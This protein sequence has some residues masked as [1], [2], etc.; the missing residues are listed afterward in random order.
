MVLTATFH[1]VVGH[2]LGSELMGHNFTKFKVY[3]NGTGNAWWEYVGEPTVGEK[4]FILSAGLALNL[5]LALVFFSLAYVFR[6]KFFFSLF[7][8]IFGFVNF[9][10]SVVY[11]FWNAIQPIGGSGD[12]G[13]ILAFFPQYRLFFIIVAGI[14]SFGGIIA[15]NLYLYK[16]LQKWIQDYG[17][18]RWILIIALLVIQ[19]LAWVLGDVSLVIPNI[20]P[21]PLV[22]NIGATLLTL[23]YI[24]IRN[25][26]SVDS[27]ET[28]KLI[29]PTI[30]FWGIAITLFLLT[31]FWLGKGI[32]L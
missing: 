25:K 32:I 10:G 7:S 17:G 12:L 19:S 5:I 15:F 31:F 26:K 24:G 2:G 11:M 28:E 14:L 27:I 22:T 29:L 9:I 20:A 23:I 21:W 16:Y 30:I 18:F 6:K 1:E 4:V 13:Q 3:P 8:L